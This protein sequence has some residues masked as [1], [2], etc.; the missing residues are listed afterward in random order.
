MGMVATIEKTCTVTRKG[1]TTL[2][3][4]FRQML[5]VPDGGQIVVRSEGNRVIM[6]RAEDEHYDPA[7]G[8]FLRVIASDIA[9]GRNVGGMSDDLIAT[10]Q[11]VA[12]EIDVDLDDPIEGDVCL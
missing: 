11:Q 3:L 8:S 10:L 4:P 5:G 7:I 9:A 6:E 1:Q 2:P 12:A